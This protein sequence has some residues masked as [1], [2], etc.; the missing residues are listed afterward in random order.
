MRVKPDATELVRLPNA[1]SMNLLACWHSA[2]AKPLVSILV[3]PCGE[4]MISIVFK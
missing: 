2:P 1:C 3:S 4:T